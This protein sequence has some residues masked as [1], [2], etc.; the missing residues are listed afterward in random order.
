MTAFEISTLII[1]TAT[2]GLLVWQ[3]RVAVQSIKADHERRKKQATTEFMLHV[4]PLWH[5]QRR[6]I[7]KRWGD[8]VLTNKIL[9]EID[10]DHEAYELVRT[11]LGQLEHISVGVNSGVYDKDLLFRTSGSHLIGI[12]HRMHPYIMRAQSK[13]STAYI[14]YVQLMREFEERKREKPLQDG[15]IEHS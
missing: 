3:V 2:A 14:E 6:M 5:D 8:G 10:K 7:E 9:D 1:A 11:L 4:R 12:Y 13:L 15:N